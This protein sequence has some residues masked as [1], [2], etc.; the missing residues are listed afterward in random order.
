[1]KI[2]RILIVLLAIISIVIGI[3]Y[4]QVNEINKNLMNSKNFNSKWSPSEEMLNSYWKNNNKLSNQYIDR[5]FDNNYEIINTYDYV[6]KLT[7]S[8][9]DSNENGIYERNK[10]FNVIGEVVGACNDK[11]EDGAIDELIMSLD[12]NNELKFID[13]DIDGRYEKVIMTNKKIHKITEINIDSL[14]NHEY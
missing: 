11:D 5:N 7:Q 13:S 2:E 10:I 12:N 4:Y 3:K 14:F 8:S 9:Y 1:M 6:G